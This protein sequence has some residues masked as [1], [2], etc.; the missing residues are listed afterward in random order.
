[1]PQYVRRMRKE[2]IDSVL[3]IDREAF[4]TEWPPPNLRRELDN[5]LAH[6][7]VACDAG[8]LVPP[9][10][11]AT[12]VRADDGLTGI[13]MRLRRWFSSAPDPS[14]SERRATGPERIIGFAGIWIMADEAHVTTI[15]T[16]IDDRRKGIG[17]LLLQSIVHLTVTL[18]AA[19][20]TLEVRVSNDSAQALYSKYG[21][22]QMGF[23]RGYY[24]DNLED[25]LLMSTENI[26]AA[27]FQALF[28]ELTG[29]YRQ[30]WGTE[31]YHLDN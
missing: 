26:G 27:S 28:R 31:R 3:E 21:F 11:A 8:N 9:S 25:A 13:R 16:R 20:V 5:H 10:A 2:D 18:S 15:A 17:E 29:A 12:A 19:I 6:Y 24:T 1:M 23:R 30:R 22:R 4:P 7:I 14:V